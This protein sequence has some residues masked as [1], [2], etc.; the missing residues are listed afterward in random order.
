V[1]GR[2]R[3]KLIEGYIMVYFMSEDQMS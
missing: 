1:S 2:G 3:R